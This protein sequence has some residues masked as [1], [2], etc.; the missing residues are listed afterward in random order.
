[1]GSPSNSGDHTESQAERHHSEPQIFLIA[2]KWGKE[3]KEKS[4]KSQFGR[5][6]EKKNWMS[7]KD[8]IWF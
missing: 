3:L 5:K 6:T 4:Y 1:M 7:L 2:Q 8:R